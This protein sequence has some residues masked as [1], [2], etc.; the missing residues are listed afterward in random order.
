MN[1]RSWLVWS[2]GLTSLLLA[3]C[4]GVRS[5]P[6]GSPRVEAE[7]VYL[8]D[9]ACLE[10]FRDG[11]ERIAIDRILRDAV[12]PLADVGLR[13]YPV[14]TERYQSGQKRPDYVMTIRAAH[15]EPVRNLATKEE[16]KEDGT[17]EKH[18]E[19]RVTTV[20]AT[21]FATIEKRQAD[22]PMLKVGEASA[23]GSAAP[24]SGEAAGQTF[25]L[26]RQADETNDTSVDAVTIERAFRSAAEKA[27][28]ELQEAIDR[29]LSMLKPAAET[30][31][32]SQ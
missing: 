32:T 3:S 16:K 10:P 31:G 28:A 2:L 11:V 26:E 24:N 27:L 14:P 5:A 18:V 12:D 19:A 30:T 21:V 20:S 1:A 7:V 6:K 29:D 13:F 4:Q 23:K 22:G 15:I 25:P 9:A 17:T 8:V